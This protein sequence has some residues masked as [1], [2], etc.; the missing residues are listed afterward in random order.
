MA[1]TTR[2]SLLA[3]VREGGDIPWG[4]FYATYKPL[5]RLCGGDCGLTDDEK[6]ELVQKVMCEIFAKDIIGRYDPDRVP[7]DVVFRHDPA[8]GR[9]RHYLRRIIRNQA[10]KIIRERKNGPAAPPSGA[11][12]QELLTDNAL[13][14]AWDL[15]WRRHL[16]NM[17]VA[18]LRGRVQPETYVAFEMYALQNRPARE[19]AK[20]LNISVASVYTAKSRCAATLREIIDDLEEK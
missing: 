16:A 17:A 18:E 4:E 8:R 13:E 7:D 19:V 14:A 10:L 20:F 9:F 2:K 15:E 3:R 12:E 5:I 1:F 11:A 6:D